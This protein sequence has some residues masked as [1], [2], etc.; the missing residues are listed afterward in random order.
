MPFGDAT[1]IADAAVA[2]EIA[3]WDALFAWSPCEAT[4]RGCRSP[5][6]RWSPSRC[7]SGRRSRPF[8]ATNRGTSPGRHTR[9]AVYGRAIL[10]AGLRVEGWT[11]FGAGRLERR[12][13]VPGDPSSTG[14][15]A[16]RSRVVRPLAFQQDRRRDVALPV[17]RRPRLRPDP[18]AAAG[19]AR[20]EGLAREG[21][22]RRRPSTLRTAPGDGQRSARSVHK[23]IIARPPR[24]TTH[25]PAG[26]AG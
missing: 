25:R 18:L 22:A 9:P 13:R 16:A 26:C 17:D 7:G 14:P 3:R 20:E 2:A 8:P 19:R 5:P 1:E 10:G 4:T 6:P 21:V 24:A 23:P 12:R 11:A 15:R